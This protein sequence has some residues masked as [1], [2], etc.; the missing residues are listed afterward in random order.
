M[1]MA[2]ARNLRL[3]PNATYIPLTRIG[4]YALG[5]AKKFTQRKRYQHVGIFAL[6]DAKVPNAN[7]FA[8]QW[9][10]G[11]NLRHP[12]LDKNVLYIYCDTQ[13][14]LSS[15]T[16]SGFMCLC[17]RLTVGTYVGPVARYHRP[18]LKGW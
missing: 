13:H 11:L 5:D 7:C 10:I 3:G 4:G 1:Y 17:G 6:G 18:P 8:L 2:N 14:S 12:S 15:R 16:G 9:N